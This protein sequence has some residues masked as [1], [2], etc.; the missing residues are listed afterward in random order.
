MELPVS[1][2]GDMTTSH[3]LP[4]QME[5]SSSDKEIQHAQPDHN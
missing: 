3:H 1:Q 2:E 5:I 4:D